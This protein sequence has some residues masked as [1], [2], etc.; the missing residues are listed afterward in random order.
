MEDGYNLNVVLATASKTNH[1][2]AKLMLQL[3]KSG[4]AWLRHPGRGC[5]RP[6]RYNS[7]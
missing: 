1:Q 2:T 3:I 7:V 5:L 4:S 6:G